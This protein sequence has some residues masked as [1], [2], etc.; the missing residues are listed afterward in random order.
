M[1]CETV[2]IHASRRSIIR[3][4][5]GGI[6]PIWCWLL[7]AEN[8]PTTNRTA[9]N[10]VCSCDNR[11]AWL[12]PSLVGFE[13]S[14]LHLFSKLCVFITD[15][16]CDSYSQNGYH[17]AAFMALLPQ[18]L[19]YLKS[20]LIL[21]PLMSKVLTFVESKRWSSLKTVPPLCCLQ[22]RQIQPIF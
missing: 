11:N 13:C 14:S 6:Q 1:Y 17:H 18:I 2:E 15:S 5:S 19:V 12:L 4:R 21:R 9:E 3:K 8:F 10:T 16:T 20:M 7:S 22:H